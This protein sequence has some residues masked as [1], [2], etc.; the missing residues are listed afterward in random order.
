MFGERL[1]EARKSYGITQEEL[2]KR[3]GVHVSMIA[4]MERGTKQASP[5][6]IADI[7]TELGCSLD[8]LIFGK[9]PQLE[10]MH[11]KVFQ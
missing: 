4:Q 2:A 5:P 1:K 9:K 8:F 6:L 10:Y 11:K 3:I 7:A